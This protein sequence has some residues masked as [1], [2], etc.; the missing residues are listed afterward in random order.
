MDLEVTRPGLERLYL[1]EEEEEAAALHASPAVEYIHAQNTVF[2]K[3]KFIPTLPDVKNSQ[4][5]QVVMKVSRRWIDF[6]GYCS[7]T[8]G[9]IRGD[10]ENL[11]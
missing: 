5:W 2:R 11:C 8:G 7:V 9:F 6:G 1:E 10:G 4:A 3:M